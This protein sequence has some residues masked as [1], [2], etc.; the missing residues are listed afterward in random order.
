MDV[1][2]T[3]S[4]DVDHEILGALFPTN[5]KEDHEKKGRFTVGGFTDVQSRTSTWLLPGVLPDDDLVVLVGEEGIG[6]GL[7]AV[8]VIA[9]VTQAGHNVLII[10]T[11]D[12]LERVVRPR[13][14][15]GPMSAAAFSCSVIPTLCKISQ[16]SRT[17]C[18]KSPQ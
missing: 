10:A 13:L 3:P 18:P 16:H 2:F 9:R 11:E 7:F 1:N 14:S 15:P 8:D 6:K 4:P 17:T 5:G 12:D